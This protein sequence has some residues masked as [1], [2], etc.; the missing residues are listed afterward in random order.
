[1]P[2]PTARLL[3]ASLALASLGCSVGAVAQTV[4]ATGGTGGTASQ[5]T[6]NALATTQTARNRNQAPAFHILGI[7]VVIQAPVSAPY[8]SEAAYST[9]AG[10]PGQGPNAILA[11]SD[12]GVP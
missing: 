8:N 9:F 1:M 2:S 12:G 6:P 11:A 4:S 7:P 3:A 5:V 10:Q